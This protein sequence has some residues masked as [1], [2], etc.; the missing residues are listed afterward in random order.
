MLRVSCPPPPWGAA[1]TV[2][3]RRSSAGCRISEAGTVSSSFP[4]HVPMCAAAG[5]GGGPRAS[6]TG[7]RGAT[8]AQLT[9]VCR[10]T[11]TWVPRGWQRECRGAR[12]RRT[13]LRWRFME[14][15]VG[16]LRNRGVGCARRGTRWTPPSSRAGEG[17][18][19]AGA[20]SYP[21]LQKSS[22]SNCTLAIASRASRAPSTRTA[23]LASTTSRARASRPGPATAQRRLGT[24][25]RAAATSARETVSRSSTSGV[26][27][28][29][30][31][32]QIVGAESVGTR[33]VGRRALGESRTGGHERRGVATAG[34]DREQRC[35][36]G[37][38]GHR[39]GVVH[40]RAGRDDVEADAGER[41]RP[42]G[43]TRERPEHDRREH[44][45]E[46]AQPVEFVAAHGRAG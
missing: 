44:R 6:I 45:Q 42:F 14:H 36:G 24:P 35:P 41:R 13:A 26:S 23:S 25:A 28:D 4:R 18:S 8:R 39:V 12:R 46:Q 9:N 29:H 27:P 2:R 19:D 38:G 1:G 11:R 3:A 16:S 34:L 37:R 21:R 43:W 7:I 5:S 17:V 31:D 22:S 40:R 20:L 10:D 30:A 33:D 32:G 15:G